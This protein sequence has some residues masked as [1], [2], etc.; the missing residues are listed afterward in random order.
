MHLLTIQR[1]L[2]L[3]VACSLHWFRAGS[4]GFRSAA[5][6]RQ[7]RRRVNVSGSRMNGAVSPV[8]VDEEY[9]SG[10]VFVH[11]VREQ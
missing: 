5:R 2:I 3:A 9:L 1:A 4:L 10:S 11:T 6:W 7:A 8:V